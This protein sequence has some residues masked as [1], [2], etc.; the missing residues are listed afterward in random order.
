MVASQSTSQLN[1]AGNLYA[2]QT[3]HCRQSHPMV[4]KIGRSGHF[5]KCVLQY[6]KGSHTLI[7][8][9]VSHMVDAENMLLAACKRNFVQRK[10]FGTKYFEGG[11]YEITATLIEIARQFPILDD[12]ACKVLQEANSGLACGELLSHAKIDSSVC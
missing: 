9:P 6:P 10:E 2:I 11:V 5:K 4:V 8:L 12:L 1:V 3:P 7:C